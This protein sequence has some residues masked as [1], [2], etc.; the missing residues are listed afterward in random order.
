M[1]VPMWRRYLVNK[2]VHYHSHYEVYRG[3]LF[4]T[5]NKIILQS[6]N[7]LRI[8]NKTNF[9]NMDGHLDHEMVRTASTIWQ[10]VFLFHMAKVSMWKFIG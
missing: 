7:A 4:R 8:A 3:C 1:S 5:L 10:V 2:A 9:W 6:D